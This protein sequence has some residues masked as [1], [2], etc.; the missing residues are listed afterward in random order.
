MGSEFL[1]HQLTLSL[2]NPVA[3]LY[4]ASPNCEVL[5]MLTHAH[6]DGDALDLLLG[7]GGKLHPTGPLLPSQHRIP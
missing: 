7:H 4:S 3:T 1:T 6:K 2:N 5:H